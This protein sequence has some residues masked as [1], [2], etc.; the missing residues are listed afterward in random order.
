[1]T[2]ECD[3]LRR[4][5]LSENPSGAPTSEAGRFGTDVSSLDEKTQAL[6]CL[7][8]LVALGGGHDSYRRSV[9]A[10]LAAGATAEDVISTFV[11]VAPTVGLARLVAATT[12]L[13][14]GIGYDIDAAFENPG[15][16][17]VASDPHRASSG[18]DL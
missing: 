12:G 15:A 14:A 11:A 18:A 3:T 4:L 10:A 5:A 17:S 2:R 8:A 6:I 1:M 13:A 16:P 9:R 7:G